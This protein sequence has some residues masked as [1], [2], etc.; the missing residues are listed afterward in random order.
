[1]AVIDPEESLNKVLGNPVG[2]ENSESGAKIKR[3]LIIISVVVIALVLGEIT[4]SDRVSLFGVSLEG[5]TPE[6]LM[7]GLGIFL[8]YNFIHYSWCCY[9]LFG[10]WQLR[11][12]GTRTA[13]VTAATFGSDGV[14]YPSEPR[15]STLYNWWIRERL[16]IIYVAQ[17]IERA[18]KLQEFLDKTSQEALFIEGCQNFPHV[19]FSEEIKALKMDVDSVKRRLNEPRISVS[20]KRFDN[21]FQIL[22]RSQN[23]RVFVTELLFPNL[24][25][26]YAFLLL[27]AFFTN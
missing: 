4:A 17:Q 13:Y 5:V 1:M 21:R 27:Y 19:D 18:E 26:A 11:V 24:L 20:L 12:T 25:A 15:Q 23:L 10:E 14:D 3:N 9:D 22:L 16:R 2:F 8:G 7:T 6:K